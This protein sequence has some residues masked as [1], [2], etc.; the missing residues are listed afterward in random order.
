V[1]AL[2]VQDNGIGISPEVLP[3]IFDRFYREDKSR[4]RQVGGHGLGLAIAKN[5]VDAC[6]GTIQVE[7]Q[8]G[9]GST[10]LVR[11]PI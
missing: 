11:L 7:S 4:T 8:V 2:D 1:L 5:L 10:F 3:R 9:V 6:H